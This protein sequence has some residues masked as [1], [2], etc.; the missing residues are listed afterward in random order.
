MDDDINFGVFL[1]DEERF[2]SFEAGNSLPW[3]HRCGRL[4]FQHV[5]DSQACRTMLAMTKKQSLT[6]RVHIGKNVQCNEHLVLSSEVDFKSVSGFD[7]IAT[8][9]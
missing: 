2:Y 5:I 1:V 3:R 6:F 8:S 9:V 4:R 7:T